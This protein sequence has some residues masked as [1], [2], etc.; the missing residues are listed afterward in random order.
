MLH[1]WTV[2]VTTWFKRF[3][4]TK[5]LACLVCGG[6]I[7]CKQHKVN[8]LL[9]NCPLFAL[10]KNSTCEMSSFHQQQTCCSGLLLWCESSNKNRGVLKAQGQG[11]HRREEDQGP[12]KLQ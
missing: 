11:A 2:L 1:I 4:C 5:V 9:F 10:K 3:L 12:G 8:Q 7:L 6:D